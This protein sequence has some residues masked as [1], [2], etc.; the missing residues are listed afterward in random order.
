M[1]TNLLT[2][3][4]SF[5]FAVTSFAQDKTTVTANSSDISDNL[6]LRAVATIFGDA[7]DLEDFERRLNDPKSQISNLDLNNDNYVDY[8]RVIESV[9]GAAH[10]IV[11][12]AVLD[13]D[14]YQDVAS[15]EVERDNN[16]NVQVQVVG[17]VYMYGSNYI[18]EPVYVHR[19]VIYTTF[20]VSSY[21]PY[22][23]SWYWNYYPTYYTYWRPFPI[24]RYRNHIA[25][26]INF[27]HSYHY[28]T[29]R[30][31]A[32]AYNTYYGRRCN[33]YERRYPNH[34]FSHRNSGYSNRYEMDQNRSISTRVPG[35][36]ELAYNNNRTSGQIREGRTNTEGSTRG[37]TSTRNSSSDVAT[38][39]G[40]SS[41]T[42]DNNTSSTRNYS[43]TRDNNT[44][45]TRNYS[46]TRDT[47][48]ITSTPRDYSST[49]SNSS[50]T[51]NY[52]SIR[53]SSATRNNNAQ[54]NTS[55]SS[56]SQRESTNRSYSGS[57]R[58]NG[59]SSNNRSANGRGDSQRGGRG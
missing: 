54:M 12:Q 26:H 52:E 36:R 28:V 9:E 33:G 46:S 10:I 24:F 39:R 42:R 11:I 18:Y 3:I 23:S 53:S 55:R 20:W 1:K 21:R 29:T 17:D 15:I 35:S 56:S 43:S 2:G 32:Y 13:K 6:D 58:Q 30:R 5:F 25:V 4:F 37:Y 49:R 27:G 51:R 8:L 57:S 40:H 45:G 7:S 50:S 47:K 34:S 14:I 16:N 38:T 31:C 22:C 41:I 59:S 19:P 44:N 48:S